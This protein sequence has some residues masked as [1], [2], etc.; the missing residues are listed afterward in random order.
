M[1]KLI[2]GKTES[3]PRPSGFPVPVFPRIIFSFVIREVFGNL[4]PLI[5][6][7]PPLQA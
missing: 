6:Y 1:G 3:P 5:L 2:R 7:D 4:P